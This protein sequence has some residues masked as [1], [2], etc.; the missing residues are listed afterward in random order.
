MKFLSAFDNTYKFIDVEPPIRISFSFAF[1][2]SAKCL[3]AK[4]ILSP[5]IFDIGYSAYG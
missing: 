1:I 2:I 4:S 3:V 5:A